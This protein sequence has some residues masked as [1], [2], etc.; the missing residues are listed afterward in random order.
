MLRIA[1]K[2]AERGISLNEDI[3]GE[4]D[5]PD[6]PAPKVRQTQFTPFGSTFLREGLSRSMA[7]MA[8]STS[9]PISGCFARDCK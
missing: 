2:A 6:R 3:I 5:I 4:G 7:S 8:E 1:G 9:L